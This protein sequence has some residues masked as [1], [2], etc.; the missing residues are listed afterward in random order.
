MKSKVQAYFYVVMLD[1]LLMDKIYVLMAVGVFG[2]KSWDH[3]IKS[4]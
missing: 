2:D 3:W 1:R 4:L